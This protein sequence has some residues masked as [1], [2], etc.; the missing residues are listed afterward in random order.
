MT[1]IHGKMRYPRLPA[2]QSIRVFEAAARH[3]NFTKAGDE[4]ALT[5][6]GVSK[7]I[8]GLE[9]FLGAAL[10]V[11]EGH[12][13]YL[14]KA[15][16]LL[17]QR[18]SQA[19]DL[20]QQAVNEIQHNQALLRLQV[21]P[22]FAARWLIPR[23][24]ELKQSQPELDLHI[25]TTWMRTIHDSISLKADELALHACM[26][27]ADTELSCE[28]LRQEWLCILASPTY[29][30][31]NG[32]IHAAKDLIGQTLIH[33]RLDGHIHWQAWN[34][35]LGRQGSEEGGRESD[36]LD[37]SQGYEFET[38]DMALS[39]A[40][41]GIGLVV[42]DVFYAIEALADKRLIIPFNMPIL[43]GLDYLLIS[44]PF[45]ANAPV[46]PAM[47]LYKN[48]LIQQVNADE[49]RLVQV[50]KEIGLNP[51]DKIE[52]FAKNK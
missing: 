39:A 16:E 13:L 49:Q 10:F 18:A 28:R 1:N 46:H 31:Q 7:Q 41:N 26:G 27:Y 30:E 43:L 12:Q 3:L 20:L 42:C 38:L 17:Q 14:T 47:T 33:T 40:E 2:Q 36:V 45:I 22:T 19:L 50:L 29:L 48:W 37:V 11:R 35:L 5:Q 51:H 32:P 21:P 34:D 25:E 52:A 15:G 6:S 9:S 8:K 44:K 4:L 24:G 23:M